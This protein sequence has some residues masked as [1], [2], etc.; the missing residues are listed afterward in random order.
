MAETRITPFNAIVLA[1]DR[2]ADDPLLRGSGVHC[3]AMLEID[4]EPMVLRVLRTLAQSPH[5][6]KRYLSGPQRECLD[7]NATLGQLV[8]SQ[9][10]EWIEPQGTPSTSAH[11]ALAAVDAER[12]TL[13]TTADHPLLTPEIIDRFCV[14]SRAR[15]A[16]VTVGLCRYDIIKAGFPGIKKT[17]LKFSNGDYCGC[18]LFAFMTPGAHRLADEWRKVESQRKNPLR[19]IRLLGWVAVLRYL[20]GALSL[21]A[22]LERLSRRLKLRIRAVELPFAEA[23]VDVDSMADRLIVQERLES[24]YL[25]AKEVKK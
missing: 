7:Q 16:D 23:A 24:N 14:D 15:D 11:H 17:I 10:V 13:I 3:K 6:Q 25:T 19:V 18:N 2:G 8:A 4:G 20:S 21:Q 1:G 12:P 5:I 22:A 9:A